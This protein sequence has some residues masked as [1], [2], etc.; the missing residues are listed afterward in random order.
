MTSWWVGTQ[1]TW[2]PILDIMFLTQSSD[3]QAPIPHSL[4]NLLTV[5]F[6]GFYDCSLDKYGVKL[7]LVTFISSLLSPESCISYLLYDAAYVRTWIRK[8]LV[9]MV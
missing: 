5:Y 6:K 3:S 7:S 8:H 2:V 1:G 4:T 9:L